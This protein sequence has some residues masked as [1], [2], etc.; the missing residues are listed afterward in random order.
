[1]DIIFIVPDLEVQPPYCRPPG[2]LDPASGLIDPHGT[3]GSPWGFTFM[4][5][6][7]SEY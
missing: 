5:C 1:M 3:C 6:L 7:L 2:V 4:V